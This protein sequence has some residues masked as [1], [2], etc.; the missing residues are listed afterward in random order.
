VTFTPTAN[1]AINGAVSITDGTS[2]SPQLVSLSGIGTGGPTAS[3]SFTPTTLS[4]TSQAVGTVSA[5][6][7]V[8]VKN[9]SA[10]S[11]TLSGITWSGDF[12]ATGSGTTPCAASLVLVAGASCTLNVTLAPALGAS[13]TINGA[14]VLADNSSV[15]QQ[16]LDV[17]GAAALPLTF[18]PTTLTFTAQTVATA[19]SAQT[20]TVTNNLASTV[21]PTIT[22]NGE[23]A[24]APGGAT[25]CGSTLNAHAKCTFTVTFTPRAVG[26]RP[27]AIT[28]TDAANPSAQ[29][30]TVTGTGQ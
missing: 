23:F 2:F 6:K 15:S 9:T 16:I 20:V 12:S 1:G 11:V 19:S 27:G 8:T 29:T 14:I 4:F 3:L 24:A 28:V 7:T 10:N 22:G 18:A 25:P 13:G 21:S 30:L 5:A 17:K 26:T